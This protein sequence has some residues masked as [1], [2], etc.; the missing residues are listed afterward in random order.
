MKIQIGVLSGVLCCLIL[1]M[2]IDSSCGS[3]VITEV[4]PDRVRYKPGETVKVRVTISNPTGSVSDVLLEGIEN[5][6]LNESQKVFTEKV[7]LKPG[8]KKDVSISYRTADKEYGRE[9]LVRLYQDG[10]EVSS[11]SEYFGVSKLPLTVATGNSYDFGKPVQVMHTIFYVYPAS[12]QESLRSVHFFK[13]KYQTY[14]EFFSWSPGDLAGL[15]PVEDPFRSG[16]ARMAYRSVETVKQQIKLLKE[17]GMVPVSYIYGIAREEA[18]YKLFQRHPEWFTPIASYDM[19]LRDLYLR[20]NFFD[21]DPDQYAKFLFAAA[22]NHSLKEV[23]T[24]IAEQII[25]CATEYGFEGVRFDCRY[26]EV[27]RG[28]MDFFGKEIASTKEE[29]DRISADAIRTVKELV[30][31]KFPEFVFGYNLGYDTYSQEAMIDSGYVLT[32]KEL[33]ADGGWMLDE[34]PCTYQNKTS[35]YHIWRVYAKH[36]ASWGDTIRKHGGVYGPFD[37]RRGGA[38]YTVDNIYSSIFRLIGGNHYLNYYNSSVPNWGDVG[39]F[40]T[41]FGAY[42]FG[43]E[44]SRIDNV[45]DEIEVKS[46]APIWWEEFVFNWNNSEGK[47]LRIVHLVNPPLAEEVEGDPESKF[48]SAVS[49]VEVICSGIAGKRPI[50]AYLLTAEPIVSGGKPATQIVKLDLKRLSGNK[51]SVKVPSVIFWK[52]VVFQL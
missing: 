27:R 6:E 42:L 1:G 9:M 43:K 51:V 35:P 20:R 14:F 11:A 47:K 23:Q 36:M 24:Y 48:R 22:L 4:W 52:M 3:P 28:E 16:L 40:A 45:K 15:A 21:F 34:L 38:K 7:S 30:R 10:K 50:S 32:F 17:V 29:A 18:G 12:Y 49:D 13:K 25:K 44:L 2:F 41:R 39:Q 46:V 5:T 31:Q 37:F 26:L 33:C 8:E 19:E